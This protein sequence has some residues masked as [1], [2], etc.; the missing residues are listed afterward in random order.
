MK[1]VRFFSAA[2][3]SML[4]FTACNNEEGINQPE[5]PQAG[6]ANMT[7]YIQTKQTAGTRSGASQQGTK[8]ES[9][10]KELEFYVFN[11][12]QSFDKYIKIPAAASG[13]YTFGVTAGNAKAVLVAANMN[14][15]DLGR[16]SLSEVREAIYNHEI[17]TKI[18]TQ[19]Q[20]GTGIPMAG[21]LMGISVS[22]EEVESVDI[23]ISRLYGKIN[24]PTAKTVNVEITNTKELE[25]LELLWNGN[26]LQGN[27]AFGIKGYVVVNG[28][29]KSY[30][31]PNYGIAGESAQWDHNVWQLGNTL[32]NYTAS[33]YQNNVLGEV[34]SGTSFLQA[35]ADKAESGVY[36]YENSPVRIDENEFLGFKP[37]TVYAII[38]EADLYDDA[39]P[40]STVTRYWRINVSKTDDKASRFKV[41]RNA[42]YNVDIMNVRSIGYGTPGEAEE[43]KPIIPDVDQTLIEANITVA[44]WRVYNEGA[45]I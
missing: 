22:E 21:E 20:E 38:V 35:K 44:D 17:A 41:L 10:V 40:A 1:I 9:Q 32:A 31:F 14:L 16:P 3:A 29:K 42:I 37:A 7:V 43:E 18:D 39:N 13:E 2:V 6:T 33:Q 27:I 25:E 30:A 45:D 11:D 34:Y 24:A 23:V 4:I 5:I 12:D 15:T 26:A 19:L 8:A 28:L 36:V